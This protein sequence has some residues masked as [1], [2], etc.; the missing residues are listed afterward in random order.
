MTENEKTIYDCD[1]DK[2][3]TELNEK[4]QHFKSVADSVAG[5]YTHVLDDIMRDIKEQIIDVE[6]PATKT[7]ERYFL[8]LTNALY[9]I[10]S[11]AENADIYTTLSKLSQKES[12][13]KSYLE[14]AIPGYS[15]KS[16][17]RTAAEL[18]C[19]ATIESVEETALAAI[20]K[21]TE[22]IVNTKIDGAKEMVRTLSKIL[23]VRASDS[24]VLGSIGG[25]QILNESI[26][27]PFGGVM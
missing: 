22:S 23:S 21:A 13:A 8:E 2:S 7:I 14:S 9:F 5:S 10:G 6:E 4:V 27:E 15:D 16:L 12:Y 17:K 19:I 11:N 3:V 20:C 18:D 25:K 26:N 24:Q 1:V